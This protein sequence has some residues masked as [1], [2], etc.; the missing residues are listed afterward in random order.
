V[1]KLNE[2]FRLDYILVINMSLGEA[3]FIFTC[4]Q[5]EVAVNPFIFFNLPA[6]I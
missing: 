2:T 1:N 5:I 6:I 4:H 3:L